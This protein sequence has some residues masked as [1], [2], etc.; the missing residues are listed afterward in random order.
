[1]VGN[2]W[3]L[4][5]WDTD[6]LLINHLNQQTKEV[7]DISLSP[8]YRKENWDLPNLRDCPLSE[9][10][11]PVSDLFVAAKLGSKR[12]VFENK[13]LREGCRALLSKGGMEDPKAE[14]QKGHRNGQ[15]SQKSSVQ[16]VSPWGKCCYLRTQSPCPL[17]C[18]L[19]FIFSP[20]PSVYL[21]V[22]P[23]LSC[24]SPPMCIFSIFQ[25]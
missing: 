4:T 18:P 24:L 8:W 21:L 9:Y 20:L 15:V 12:P 3:G 17:L 25:F 2:H 14:L 16:G 13:N 1:M 22:L 6:M 5:G 19:L 10:T 7:A 11:N 23:S